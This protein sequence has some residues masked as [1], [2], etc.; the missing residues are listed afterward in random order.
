MRPEFSPRVLPSK[1]IARSTQHARCACIAATSEGVGNFR[2]GSKRKVE[3]RV[4]LVR[5]KSGSSICRHTTTFA[6]GQFQTQASQQSRLDHDVDARLDHRSVAVDS[7]AGAA[8]RARMLCGIFSA[9]SLHSSLSLKRAGQRGVVGVA[10]GCWVAGGDAAGR[11]RGSQRPFTMRIRRELH[12]RTA[13]RTTEF[14]TQMP[15]TS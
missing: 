15:S 9:I 8:R 14:R 13:A 4:A 3:R 10:A 2:Y 6:E 12:L 7:I 1:G 5:C 11:T